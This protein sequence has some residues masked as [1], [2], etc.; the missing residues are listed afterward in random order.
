VTFTKH[1]TQTQKNISVPHGINSKTDHIF[2]Q[3]ASLKRYK[4]IDL[5]HY[6]LCDHHGLMLDINNRNNKVF[7]PVEPE[8]LITEQKSGLRWKLGKKLNTF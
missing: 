6:I 2:R 8:Q 4:K 3:R 7:K 1:F 5:T